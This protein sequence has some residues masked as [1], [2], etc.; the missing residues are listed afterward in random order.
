MK[1]IYILGLAVRDAPLSPRLPSHRV[2]ALSPIVWYEPLASRGTAFDRWLPTHSLADCDFHSHV[3]WMKRELER[4]RGQYTGSLLLLAWTSSTALW[5]MRLLLQQCRARQNAFR[6]S[7]ADWDAIPHWCTAQPLHVWQSMQ[8]SLSTLD[9]IEII[10]PSLKHMTTLQ[11]KTHMPGAGGSSISCV[12]R[13]TLRFYPSRG[14]T[15]LVEKLPAF[16]RRPYY[17]IS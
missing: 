7:T 8:A 15:A 11:F 4:G 17:T 12:Y 6:K 2:N 13:E 9:C 1:N 3:P 5:Q 14:A 10:I 16:A